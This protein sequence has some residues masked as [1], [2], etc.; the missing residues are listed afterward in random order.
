M[1]ALIDKLSTGIPA[2]LEELVTLGRTLKK[3][4][5]D[6]M[7]YFGRPGTSNRANRSDL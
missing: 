4:A 1:Q 7:A 2:A 3:R 5:A 6:I